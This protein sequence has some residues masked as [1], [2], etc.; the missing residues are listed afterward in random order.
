MAKTRKQLIRD[1]GWRLEAF[2]WD[3]VSAILG[4]A[5]VDG[6]SAFGGAALR[7]LGPLTPTHRT[8]MRNLRLAF[9]EM[10]EPAR[11]RL[12]RD[13]WESLGRTFFEFFMVP[14]IIADPSRV[15]RVNF[16][17]VMAVALEGGPVI[18]ISGHF[19]NFE[20]MGATL[21]ALGLDGQLAYRPTN[22]PYVDKR[23]RESRAAYGLKLAVTKGREGGRELMAT[24]AKGMSVAFLV[25]QKYR[26]G[27]LAPF[28][29]HMVNT[30]PA[31]VR[32]AMRFGV[33]LQTMSIQRTKGVR[34]RCT[35]HEPIVIENTGDREADLQAGL[36]KVNAFI[37]ARIRE[38]P[39][40]WWWVHRRF[41]DA[42]YAELA[43]KGY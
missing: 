10:D 35:I 39:A 27:P 38:A 16:E 4:V 12:A 26:E 13:H 18:G 9:P 5:P 31:A 34:F 20:I 7:L 2:G 3:V 36:A 29:G 1:L 25:D 33:N 8:V 15:E 28:F 6:A 23:I 30:Q 37:E 41:P 42:V 24:L 43:A 19:A 14:R 22:N 32:W 40:Q 11:R 17:R 21:L